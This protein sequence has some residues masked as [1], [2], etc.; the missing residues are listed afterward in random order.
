MNTQKI[1]QM[2]EAFETVAQHHNNVEFWLARDLQ[3]LLGYT[4]W[5]KFTNVLEKAQTACENSGEGKDDH[6][7]RVGRMVEIGSGGEREVD[8]YMLTRYAC[9]LT[10]QNADSRKE[11]VAFAQSYFALQT[12]K[13]E[14]IEER[15]KLNERLKARKKLTQV[16][17][18]LSKNIYERGV[19]HIGFA[20]IR[21]LGDKAL[22]GGF[23]T[24]QMKQKM[25]IPKN[26]PLADFL[27]EITITAKSLATQ[28]TNF[29]VKQKDLQGEENI[30][31]EHISS[32]Q[33]LRDYLI[34]QGIRPEELPPE[35]DIKKLERRIKTADKKLLKNGKKWNEE[36][37][38][39]N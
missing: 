38:E 26:R 22:F 8:D 4:K 12:R 20:R 30:A 31:K 5:D 25:Q 21:S 29:N 28:V 6:F 36:D 16:E 2:R 15:L 13:Q 1:N 11:T 23:S 14:L 9:Y 3:S 17:K 34:K 39:E 32:N 37:S 19:D 7:L 10:A 27:P 18:E 35:E 33:D 24:D